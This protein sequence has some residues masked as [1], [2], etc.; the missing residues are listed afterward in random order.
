MHIN[1]DDSVVVG[2][3]V[4]NITVGIIIT[5]ILVSAAG[6]DAKSPVSGSRLPY[7]DVHYS[8]PYG[9]TY[10]P[11]SPFTYVSSGA[12]TTRMLMELLSCC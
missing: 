1:I 12:T 6:R 11:F 8:L 2:I 3:I 10:L 5:T 7:L 9:R 4:I